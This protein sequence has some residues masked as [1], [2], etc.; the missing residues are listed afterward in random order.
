M[1]ALGCCA[2]LVVDLVLLQLA[3]RVEDLRVDSALPV[4]ELSITEISHICPSESKR[5]REYNLVQETFL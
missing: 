5:E 4:F 2:H 1:L 3:L